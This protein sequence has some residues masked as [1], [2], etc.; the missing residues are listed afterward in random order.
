MIRSLHQ[1]EAATLIGVC[2][3]IYLNWEKY[4]R[5]PAARH[6]PGIIQYLRYDPHSEPVTLGERMAAKRRTEGWSMH[7][8]ARA[9]GIDEGTWRALS[10]RSDQLPHASLH[11]FGGR[12]EAGYYEPTVEHIGEK[13]AR[14]REQLDRGTVPEAQIEFINQSERATI[15]FQCGNFP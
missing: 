5:A 3:A 13:A 8:A 1:D 9:A 10:H 7:Q 11:R 12:H 14:W 4:Q 15:M 6:W 2:E